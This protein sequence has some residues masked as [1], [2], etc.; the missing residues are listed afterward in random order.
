VAREGRKGLGVFRVRGAQWAT[1]DLLVT[2]AHV[3]SM[4]SLGLE[5]IAALR[6]T[7]C[8]CTKACTGRAM[9]TAEISRYVCVEVICARVLR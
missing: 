4:G 5:D 7:T 2:P 6:D 1:L 3:V 8:I 9:V